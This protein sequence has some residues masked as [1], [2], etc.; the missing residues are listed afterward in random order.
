MIQ[1]V[2]ILYWKWSVSSNS[3]DHEIL[4]IGHYSDN[5]ALD[6]SHQVTAQ[7]KSGTILNAA[8]VCIKTLKE[9]WERW[10]Q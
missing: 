10:T 1:T 9:I 8:T 3:Q 4:M 2:E 7:Q 6:H 5:E